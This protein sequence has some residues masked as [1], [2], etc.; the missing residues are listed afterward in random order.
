MKTDIMFSSK[1]DEYATPQ[2]LFDEL[3]NEF[4]FNLDPCS[5]KENH[6]CNNFYTKEDDGLHKNWGGTD[7]SLIRHT[8]K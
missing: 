1:T 6:K 2:D 5:T 7:A 4:N 8:L 3:N